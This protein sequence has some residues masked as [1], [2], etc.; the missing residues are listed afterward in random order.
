M[1][2]RNQ[3]G[4]ATR[5]DV[6]KI[7]RSLEAQLQTELR[8][9]RAERYGDT[10]RARARRRQRVRF[11]IALAILITLVVL[12]GLQVFGAYHKLFS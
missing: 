8:L 6:E 2:D 7:D 9:R 12:L 11:L 5:L 3:R 1:R 10:A 4:G